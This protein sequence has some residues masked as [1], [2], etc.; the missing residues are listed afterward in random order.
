MDCQLYQHVPG[1][2]VG[3][4]PDVFI[5]GEAPGADEV[6]SHAPFVGRSGQL[7]R[8]L[9]KNFPPYYIT[10]LVKCRPPNNRNPN[11]KEIKACRPHLIR[12]LKQY[13]PSIIVLVGKV[14]AGISDQ[15]PPRGVLS[16]VDHVLD[17]APLHNL[18][19]AHILHPAAVL[20]RP[21]LLPILMEEVEKLEHSLQSYY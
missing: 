13:S 16:K 19:V 10:N 21:T 15:P 11:Q 5:I 4:N 17:Y 9:I 14:A 1:Q 8:N 2:E 18:F 3:D 6:I 12:E 7:L 20:Y